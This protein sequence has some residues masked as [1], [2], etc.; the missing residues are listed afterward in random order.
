[1]LR[2]YWFT[3]LVAKHDDSSVVVLFYK[4]TWKSA[5]TTNHHDTQKKANRII[6][7][8]YLENIKNEI[9]KKHNHIYFSLYHMVDIL[10]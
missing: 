3:D 10:G 2:V 6:L 7:A 9:Y 5:G 1:M 4:W 8:L